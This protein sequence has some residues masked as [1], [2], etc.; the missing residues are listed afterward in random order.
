MD[1]PHLIATPGSGESEKL[2][3][4]VEL[5]CRGRSWTATFPKGEGWTDTFPIYFFQ[6]LSFL[7]LEI[8]LC[9]IVLCIERKKIFLSP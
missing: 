2:K 3:K 1:A 8:I 6:G 9:K 5:C 4:G 7:H